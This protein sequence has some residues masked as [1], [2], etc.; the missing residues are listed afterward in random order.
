MSEESASKNSYAHLFAADHPWAERRPLSRSHDD[1]VRDMS[2]GVRLR[3]T[4]DKLDE[5]I[6]SGYI[7]QQD[8]RV[9]VED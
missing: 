7:Q 2:A 8:A 6:D 9:R 3:S 5:N 1:Q 4:Y